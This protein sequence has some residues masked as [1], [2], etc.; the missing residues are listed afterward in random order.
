MAKRA[1]I[2][3]SCI[4]DWISEQKVNFPVFLI[5]RDYYLV[6]INQM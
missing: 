6:S 1:A 2:N 3:V 5:L 4:L